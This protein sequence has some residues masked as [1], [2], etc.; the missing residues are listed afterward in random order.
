MMICLLFILLHLSKLR[1]LG[2]PYMA[3]LSPLRVRDL[4]DIFLRIPLK[5]LL[6]SPRDLHKY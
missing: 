2:Q 3:S 4:R 6:R 5:K 1:S